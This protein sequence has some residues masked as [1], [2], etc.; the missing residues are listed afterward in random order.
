[1]PEWLTTVLL[2]IAIWGA[3]TVGVIHAKRKKCQP[4]TRW[5]L[6]KGMIAAIFTILLFR[7][8]QVSW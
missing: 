4:I 1:M 6:V 8:L 5:D 3:A 7:A 2:A